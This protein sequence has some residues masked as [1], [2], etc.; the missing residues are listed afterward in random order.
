MLCNFFLY[1][2]NIQKYYSISSCVISIIIVFAPTLNH[3]YKQ[4]YFTLIIP[5]LNNFRIKSNLFARLKKNIFVVIKNNINYFLIENC[6][7]SYTS[8]NSLQNQSFSSSLPFYYIAQKHTTP[9]HKGKHHGYEQCVYLIGS[10]MS[11]GKCN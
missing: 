4:T 5:F 7:L 1:V 8:I 9:V 2:N 3:N 10:F 11:F 6:L